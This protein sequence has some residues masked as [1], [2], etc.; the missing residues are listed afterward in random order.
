MTRTIKRPDKTLARDDAVLWTLRSRAWSLAA[1][2]E[3][4]DLPWGL[5]YCS[6]CRLREA[7]LVEKVRDG[8]RT[9]LWRAT[10]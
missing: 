3:E 5:A 2:Q 1:L 9:P 10:S 7:G 6:L 4:L 8:S